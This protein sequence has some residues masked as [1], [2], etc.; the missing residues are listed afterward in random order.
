MNGGEGVERHGIL[1]RVGVEFEGL[2]G[3]CWGKGGTGIPLLVYVPYRLAVVGGC[4]V[5]TL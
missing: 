2:D 1:D 5:I 3:A 4:G